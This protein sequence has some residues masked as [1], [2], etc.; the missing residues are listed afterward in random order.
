[1][2]PVTGDAVVLAGV[3]LPGVPAPEV[4]PMRSTVLWAHPP[5]GLAAAWAE[6][7]CWVDLGG[8][9]DH[10]GMPPMAG[11]PM[12]LGLGRMT[13][14]G[15]PAT[16]RPTTPADVAEILAAYRGRFRDWE[17]ARPIRAAANFYRMAPGAR[18]HLGQTGRVFTVAADSGHG[19]KFGAL[20]GLDL[21]EAV[22]E[23][24]IAAVARRMAGETT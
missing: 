12:K 10:W 1:A 17:G 5:P 21:A 8:A 2:G 23:G 15:D 18:F 3:L 7:P 24:R 6:A 9:D 13:R 11:L 20:T 22:T 14:P 19:F 16:E 4:V